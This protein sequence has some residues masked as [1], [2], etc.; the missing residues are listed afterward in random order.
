MNKPARI[1]GVAVIAATA[2]A[3]CGSASNTGSGSSSGAIAGS[4]SSQAS[5]ATAQAS[6]SADCFTGSLRAAGSTAQQNAITQA[7]S[8]YQAKCPGAKISYNGT[9]SGAG[10]TSFTSKQIDFAGSDSALSPDKGEPAKAK[11]ACT[12]DAWDLPMVTGPIA[13]VYNLK[14]VGKLTLTPKLIAKIFSGKITAWNDPAIAA[15]NKGAKLPSTKI[16]VFFRSD[17]S[18]TTDNFTNYMHTTDGADWP[19]AHGKSWTG[20]VGQGK[21]KS[22]GV[23]A[24]VKSTDGAIGYDEWSYAVQNTLQMAQIDSGSGPVALSAE[25]AAEGVSSAKVVGTGKD[26]SLK[27]DYATKSPGAYPLILVTYEIVCSKY[28]QPKTGQDVRS[29]L[30]YMASP[31]FQATLPKIGSAPLPAG[32]QSKVATTIKAVS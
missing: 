20:K 31:E 6:G 32:I 25:S 8:A 5:N 21:A 26:L 30:S 23:S 19:A 4:G 10:I 15:A 1:A 18:G 11:Q 22:A 13:V 27:I 3:G 16:S 12:S 17:S 29:F 7:I 9:G 28:A 24:A 14:G 2:L